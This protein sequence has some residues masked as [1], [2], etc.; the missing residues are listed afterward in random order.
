VRLSRVCAGA[1]DVGSEMSGV[2]RKVFTDPDPMPKKPAVPEGRR[3]VSYGIGAEVGVFSRTEQK[4]LPGKVDGV[5]QLSAGKVSV[6]FEMPDGQMARKLVKA[7]SLKVRRLDPVLDALSRVPL[8]K[9][10]PEHTMPG[11]AA[12]CEK[13]SYEAGDTLIRQGDEGDAFYIIMEGR[14]RVEVDDEKQAVLRSGEY[15][16]ED[17]L[18]RERP[19]SATIIAETA[20]KALRISKQEFDEQGLR[21]RLNFPRRKAVAGGVDLAVPKKE[22]TPKTRD[23]T[24]LIVDALKSNKTLQ[25]LFELDD[26]KCNQIASVAW[27]D[28]VQAGEVLIRQGDTSADYFY[29]VQKGKFAV[30]VQK[31][32]DL[33]PLMR[34]SVRI[35]KPPPT[36]QTVIGE[37]GSFGEL[38]LVHMAPRAATVQAMEDSIVWVVDRVSFKRILAKSAEDIAKEYISYLNREPDIRKLDES[39]KLMLAKGLTEVAFSNGETIIEQGEDSDALYILCEGSVE[40][41][42]DG[43]RVNQLK[44]PEVFGEG[45]LLRNGQRRSAT[46]RVL[47]ETVKALMLDRASFELVLE[48]LHGFLKGVDTQ[49]KGSTLRKTAWSTQA[50][51]S[52]EEIR[53]TDLTIVS[54]L[55]QGSFGSVDLV[56]H[57]KT[58]KTYALKMVSKADTV[59]Q[60]MQ[61]NVIREKDIMLRLDSH[62]I[63]RLYETYN[64]ADVLYYLLELATGGELY[65]T[66]KRNYLFGLPK[67][68]KFYAAGVTLAFEHLHTYKVAHRDLKPENLLLT[69]EGHV[70][71]ADFGLAKEVPGKTFTTCGTPDYFAPEVIRSTGHNFAVDWWTLGVLIFELMAGHV[72]F[73]ADSIQ[74]VYKKIMAGV[75]TVTFPKDLRGD[76]EALV[77]SLCQRDPAERLPMKKGGAGNIKKHR[78][79]HGMMWNEMEQLRIEP[80][81]R[82]Y[83]RGNQDV[84]N[85]RKPI[86]W[87]KYV[88]DGTGWDKDFATSGG[89]PRQQASQDHF[90]RV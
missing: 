90:S 16:G 11:L 58:G 20:V 5:S 80:P 14:V 64:G 61:S 69:G 32:E 15:F 47:S 52:K 72:P 53:F 19:R 3:A 78:W 41:I 13:I 48:P 8:F 87:A 17:A 23:E 34:A 24:R 81:Y 71:L 65:N 46:V 26:A 83:V 21:R 45:A 86:K 79:F 57:N 60:R 29:I 55:G 74:L 4:W 9:C 88:D 40:V 6:L 77:K 70:K 76:C 56:A 31:E 7:D 54:A 51:H 43:R 18:L 68:A 67:H 62:F 33:A 73:E 66:Y 89:P 37:K 63:V 25:A 44:A 10:L 84:G 12:V 1:A 22:P 28:A 27:R 36:P 38:A 85:K 30:T 35:A 49:R 2:M 39:V 75:N 42:K 82:P 59:K 50:I